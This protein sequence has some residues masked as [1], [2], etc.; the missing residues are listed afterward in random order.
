M[1]R[2]AIADL[3][4]L[5]MENAGKLLT[6]AHLLI[7]ANDYKSAANRSYYA[8]FAAMRA[9]LALMGIDHKKHSGVMSDFRL[10]FIKTGK[11]RTELSDI[12]SELF[13]LRTQSDY[14][15]FYVISKNEILQQV[16]NAEVFVREIEIFLDTSW[17]DGY[18]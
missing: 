18:V 8:V 5:R 15:D 13:E 14:N 2:D 1:H 3:S 11:L 16:E 4:K 12:L 9:C 10:Q 7:D 17:G 6:S